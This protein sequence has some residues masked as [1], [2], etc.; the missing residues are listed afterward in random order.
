MISFGI[1]GHLKSEYLTL[2]KVRQN[3]YSYCQKFA[4]PYHVLWFFRISYGD[5]QKSVSGQQLKNLT[6]LSLEAILGTKTKTKKGYKGVTTEVTTPRHKENKKKQKVKIKWV[7]S[8]ERFSL[9][10]FS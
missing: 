9:M 4:D 5:R 2:I 10:P 1:L 6:F 7:A 8:H 3:P